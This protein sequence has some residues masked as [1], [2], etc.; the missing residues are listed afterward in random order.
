MKTSIKY[1][2]ILAVLLFS[3]SASAQQ[4]LRR[5]QTIFL[6]DATIKMDKQGKVPLEIRFKEG[7]Q[8][9]VVSF[10]DEYKQNFSVSENNE[11]KPFKVF[12]DQLG[13]THNRFK[14]YY[15]GL[16]LAEV[17]YLV[18]EKNGSVFFAHG[19]L[20]HELNLDVTPVLTESEALTFALG[21][22]N[23][24][25]YMW[26]NKK[27][28]AFLKKEQNDNNAT[29][30]P[31]GELMISAGLKEK[32]AENFRLVY[33]FDIYAQ[34]PLGRYY[35]DVDATNG[36]II[37]V[38][39]RL[40]Y[41]DVPGYGTTLYNGDVE[42]MVS[43][44][45]FY[46][47]P[48]PPAH[49][50]L[51]NWNAFG[52][53]GKSWWM[54]DTS[55]GNAGGYADV[56]YE[57][58]DTEPISLTG[59]GQTLNFF[60]RYAAEPP[61]SYQQYD[62]WDGMNVRIST[63]GGAT[64]NVLADPTPTYT[65]SSLYSFGSTHGEG[66]G[67]PGWTGQLDNWTEVTFDLS[68]FAGQMVQLRFAFAS[69]EYVS[70]VTAGDPDWFG[71]QIDDIVV[72]S[73]AG[74]LYTND[75][76]DMGITASN[77]V[78]E[79]TII[80]GNYRLRESGRGAGIATFDVQNQTAYQ[81]STDFVDADSNFT[82]ANDQAGVSTHWAAEATYDYYLTRHGRNSYDDAGARILSYAHYGENFVNAFWG[83]TRMTFGDGDGTNYGPLVSLDVVGHEFTHGVTEFSSG[84]IYQGES[85][86]LNESFS[87]IFGA[88]VEF[89]IE[90]SNGDWLVGEDFAL[91]APPF[92]SME[93]PN[94]RNDPDTYSGNFWA[95]TGPNDPDNGGVHTNSGV[96]N[97]FFYLL[98][99]GG[100]G[101]NDN[102]DAYSVTGIGIAEAAQIA[103]RN[104]TVY[105][106]P[107]SDYPDAR[108]A[109]INSA[110]DLFGQGSN[111][112]Q[113]VTNAWYA[114]GVGAPFGA[115][116]LNA[117]AN[118][119]YLVPGLDTLFL[120]TKI[121]NPDSH[122]VEV[123]AMI[124]SFDLSILD[125]IPMFDDGFHHDSTAGDNLFGGSW[126]VPT[127]E[128]LYKVHISTSSLDSGY[129][130]VLNDL[131]RFTTIGPLVVDSYTFTSTVIPGAY[132]LGLNLRNNGSVTTAVN[133]QASVATSD[134]NVQG[135]T[136][137]PRSFGNIAAGQTAQS[138]GG[139]SFFIQNLPPGIDASVKIFSDGYYLWSDSFSIV[140]TGIAEHET[141]IPLEF[142]LK[143]N[144]PNPF[145]PSTAI[146]FDL[147]EAAEVKLT[148]YNTLGQE[149]ATLVS[150]NLTP[151]EYNLQWNGK[152]ALGNPLSSGVYFYRLTAGSFTQTRKM[153]LMK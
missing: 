149:V 52:G 111:Q 98:S 145:N 120:T 55:L 10:F 103:Y 43:D 140:L 41:G 72:S 123:K 95:P 83:G 88:L 81:L 56:W 102:G 87:D 1:A 33:R 15:K 104:L 62:G 128:R 48:D 144:Y 91:S 112:V 106:M 54:A 60:H 57:V 22:I 110:I 2:G 146:E 38:L 63:D 24:E 78:T 152:D 35:V 137:N 134:T 49:F 23:A 73:S 18:H 7:R 89:F 64:W 26:E 142:A 39:S 124:E 14:Q 13:Q 135:I 96:Q 53:S 8:I 65:N 150:E 12:T 125:T 101:V 74:T 44:S 17:Q 136:G 5:F 67:V 130:N 58:L 115:Y 61:S 121:F 126:T 77:L 141:N 76:V 36:E 32:I 3:L 105:L 25:S 28:E 42:I 148:I 131:A 45:N 47:P 122:N 116:A 16:E 46:I 108:L 94:S 118:K 100:S 93:D 30:Y 151:G 79:T 90:G 117:T 147:P 51:D 99:E 19:R 75:G 133:I 70:T 114:V 66:P 85:G 139:Y 34:K 69:D 132:S 129:Y 86:A 4:N 119:S 59:T 27:N 31:K 29:Y 97:Y 6:T 11:I 71:W 92:R 143:Q 37:G 9:S 80:A 107:A 20:I 113:A 138:L 84:L 153:I 68:S 109:S 40:Y 50:H 127:G 21:H 82:D